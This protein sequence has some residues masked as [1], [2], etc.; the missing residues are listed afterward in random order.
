M[1]SREETIR[2]LVQKKADINAAGGVSVRIQW[3]EVGRQG[4]RL[5]IWEWVGDIGV[6]G[7][8]MW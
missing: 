2:H 4:T 5:G 1:Y 7:M 3:G 8:V 6:L